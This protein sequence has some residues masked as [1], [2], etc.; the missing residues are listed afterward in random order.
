[1]L[2]VLQGTVVGPHGKETGQGLAARVHPTTLAMSR[3]AGGHWSSPSTEH[4]PGDGGRASPK[5]G[6]EQ[7]QWLSR[8]GLLG[9][10]D[11]PCCDI[12]GKG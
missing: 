4:L 3:V 8:A 7:G 11:L 2:S 6:C 5:L 12:M 1:M 10:G 9:A